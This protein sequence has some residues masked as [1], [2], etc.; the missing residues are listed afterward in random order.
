[1]LANHERVRL[2]PASGMVSGPVLPERPAKV[3]GGAQGFVPDSGRQA[4]LFPRAPVLADG[5][6]RR[7]LAAIPLV[8]ANMHC[9]AVDGGPQRRVS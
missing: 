8:H 5:D 7:D 3:P 6:D 4:I 1:M 2:D 9:R